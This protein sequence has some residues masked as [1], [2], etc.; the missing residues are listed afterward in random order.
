MNKQHL[1]KEA[2][3]LLSDD[4]LRAAFEGVRHQALE[5]L[6]SSDAND[7]TQILRLQAQVH[8]IDQVRSELHAMVLRGAPERASQTTVV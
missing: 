4:V 8:V 6:G 7:T 5:A 1:A 2:V 3:R